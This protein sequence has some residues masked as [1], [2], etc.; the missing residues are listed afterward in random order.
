MVFDIMQLKK[1]RKHLGLTQH[2]F[3]ARAGIS[4]SMVAKIESGK[5]DPTYSYV[6]KIEN[7]LSSLQQQNELTAKD[8][9]TKKII[10]VKVDE[11]ISKVIAIMQKNSISQ[12]PVFEKNNIIGIISESSI[13]KK[14]LNNIKDKL[15]KEV[16]DETPPIIIP[17]TRL[18]VIKQL[19]QFYSCL[20][21]KE[22]GSWA[23]II[24]KAD[25]M[26]VLVK[27]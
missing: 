18:E 21:V 19:L 22:K 10:S 16:V 8:I 25:L 1:I 27:G 26:R 13:I 4:Q 24:T 11:R 17:Q 3:A 15:A 7:V 6:K 23:G 14:S 9:M 20:L 5:L 2:Q 12:I